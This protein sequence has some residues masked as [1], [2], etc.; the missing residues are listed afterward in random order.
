MVAPNCTAS[1]AICMQFLTELASII[2]LRQPFDGTPIINQTIADAVY[3]KYHEFERNNKPRS[4]AGRTFRSYSTNNKYQN[5][6]NSYIP[7]NLPTPPPFNSFPT[8]KNTPPGSN[9]IGLDSKT[10][11]QGSYDPYLS[12]SSYRLYA[13]RFCP[14]AQ[15]AIIYLAK[16]NIPVE[17]VNVNPDRSPNWYLAKSPTG[18]VPLLQHDNKYI[19]ESNVVLEYLD[20]M[21]PIN[22]ILPTDPYLKAQQKIITEKL[23]QFSNV[24]YQFFQNSNQMSIRNIDSNLNQALQKAEN[25]LTD[26]FFG[27]KQVGYAD[28]MIWPFLERLELITLNP[29][30]S[31][32]YFPGPHYPKMGAYIARMGRQPEITFAKRP[33]MHHKGYIDSFSRGSPNYDYPNNFN[34]G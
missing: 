16:K 26:A 15:R 7:Q 5:S 6:F 22:S 1:A 25:L 19:T 2:I 32:K 12:P 31:F 11:H 28:I 4:I 10:L 18:Q 8:N 30:T 23:N 34:M 27:G 33:L 17:I 14:Y 29:Y 20:D 21:F 3:D 13:M 9:I 24:M